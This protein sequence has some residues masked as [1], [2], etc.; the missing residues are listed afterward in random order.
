[1]SLSNDSVSV[2]VTALLT[3]VW[4]I[5]LAISIK[6]KPA[7]TGSGGRTLMLLSWPL[8]V[9][10]EL[11]ALGNG[12]GHS[13]LSLLALTTVPLQLYGMQMS[14]MALLWRKPHYA[15]WPLLIIAVVLLALLGYQLWVFLPELSG[16][17]GL[18]PYGE[19]LV[20]WP[21]YASCLLIAFAMLYT[22]IMQV[23]HIQQYHHD[24]PLQAVDT[25]QHK[26]KGIAG[27]SGFTVGVAFF[28]VVITALVAFGILPFQGWL[29]WFHCGV[30]FSMLTV[31]MNLCRTQN[32]SP[33]PFDHA[34]LHAAPALTEGRAL[35]IIKHA[36]AAVIE[37]KA[38]KQVGLTLE[39]FA[40]QAQL[41]PTVLCLALLKVKKQH[42]RNYIYQF[43]MK[44]AKQLLLRS[45]I[46]LDQVTKRLQLGNKGTVSHTFLK[47]LENKQ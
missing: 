31:L 44:Y 23:E 2:W 37:S 43:R 45:D 22:A 29:A 8:L 13:L 6:Q 38:Y 17:K 27:A 34:A 32:T 14:S 33:S 40:N 3:C 10:S 16:W 7:N 12:Q 28:L 11:W 4:L 9:C 46:K 26:I 42:F 20:Y 39:S 47:Y 25:R 5:L 36:D 19:P 35:A 1:M 21:V 18:A 41:D 30:A 24:L 15:R